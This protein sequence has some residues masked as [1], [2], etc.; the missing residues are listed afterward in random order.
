[1]TGVKSGETLLDPFCGT[2]GVLIEAGLMGI[3]PIGSDLREDMVKG[4][5]VSLAKFGLEARLF[6][7]DVRKLKEHVARVDAIAT[8]P[9]Y[10]RSTTMGGDIEALYSKSFEVFSDVL[11]RGRR[12][13]IIVPKEHL[14]ALGK[15]F[16]ELEASH[17]LRVHKSLT[18]HFCL[19]RN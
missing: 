5:E 12:L 4:C 2:G 7:A 13:S 9:P 18:R 14:I 3:V 11:R 8:D 1:M 6:P 15:E 10:G 16:M 17:S 19:F